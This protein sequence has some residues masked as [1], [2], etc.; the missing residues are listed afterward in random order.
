MATDQHPTPEGGPPRRSVSPSQWVRYL[1][2]VLVVVY[3]IAFM[4]LNT[5]RVSVDY[6]FFSR[7]SRLIYVI[8]VSAVLGAL[9]ASLVK[10]WRRRG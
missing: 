1:L 5:D 8:L 9:A 3:V 6:V 7:H 10:R 2:A 4:F